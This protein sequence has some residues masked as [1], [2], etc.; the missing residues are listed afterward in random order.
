MDQFLLDSNKDCESENKKG[1]SSTNG[2][3]VKKRKNRKYD[4]SYL[5][6]GFT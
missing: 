3:S 2:K 5:D 6:F 4:D 1:T